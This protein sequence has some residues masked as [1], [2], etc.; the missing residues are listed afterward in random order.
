MWQARSHRS[1]SVN[2]LVC[3]YLHK[4]SR[5]Q[6]L[7]LP[8]WS[9]WPSNFTPFVGLHALC[10][11]FSSTTPSQHKSWRGPDE[12]KADRSQIMSLTLKTTKLLLLSLSQ[13]QRPFRALYWPP[14]VLWFYLLLW[15]DH[16]GLL[17]VPPQIQQA[18]SYFWAFMPAVQAYAKWSSPTYLC[19][20]PPRPLVFLLEYYLSNKSSLASKLKYA[21]L[22]F[23][24]LIFPIVF[25]A[26]K[27]TINFTASFCLLLAS[28]H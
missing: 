2:K 11:H 16:T 28:F 8:P 27:E 26:T 5:T 3:S 17:A 22:L 19:G 20:W 25:I 9:K 13:S 14:L 4:T 12:T 23:P 6:P 21:N 15:C 1:E 24:S 18:S 10:S 7:L